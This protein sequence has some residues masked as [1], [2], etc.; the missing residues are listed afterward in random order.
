VNLRMR[1]GDRVVVVGLR[2]RAITHPRRVRP[3]VPRQRGRPSAGAWMLAGSA[4]LRHFNSFA[5]S[6]PSLWTLLDVDGPTPDEDVTE[7]NAALL[8]PRRRG[9]PR[10]P[11]L[12][13]SGLWR[14]REG[15]G[16]PG[17]GRRAVRP[18][19]QVRVSRRARRAHAGSADGSF[20]SELRGVVSGGGASCVAIRAG[21]SLRGGGRL[22][23]ATAGLC[24]GATIGLFLDEFGKSQMRPTEDVDCILPD[25]VSYATWGRIAAGLRRRVSCA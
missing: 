3:A 13:A 5:V 18:R 17:G 2:R 25:A 10:R 21:R 1:T 12:R 16:P 20:G 24:G 6:K 8:R 4:T 23:R 7:T 15:G 22:A 14:G 9:A 11:Q 19:D